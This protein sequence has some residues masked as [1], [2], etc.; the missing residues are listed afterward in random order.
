MEVWENLSLVQVLMVGLGTWLLIMGPCWPVV[1]G[2]GRSN[3]RM[4]AEVMPRLRTERVEAWP[5]KC[6][7][8]QVLLGILEGQR[9]AERLGSSVR[10]RGEGPSNML[11][12]G[13]FHSLSKKKEGIFVF[14]CWFFFFFLTF[15]TDQKSDP[16]K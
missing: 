4:W 5:R 6:D 15:Q 10:G 12:L 16:V 13:R 1:S 8:N 7:P 14:L 2:P 9:V 3:L 11:Y